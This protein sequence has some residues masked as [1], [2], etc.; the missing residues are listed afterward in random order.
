MNKVAGI[1]TLKDLSDSE[2]RDLILKYP[3][4]QNLYHAL[5]EQNI[6]FEGTDSFQDILHRTSLY[7][8]D[9]EFLFKKIR[10]LKAELQMEKL[11]LMELANENEALEKIELKDLEEPTEN[12]IKE[13]AA[14]LNRLEAKS[15]WENKG[16]KQIFDDDIDTDLEEDDYFDLSSDRLMPEED[17]SS[18]L[19]MLEKIIDRGADK[20]DPF[21]LDKQRVEFLTAFSKTLDSNMIVLSPSLTKKNVTKSTEKDGEVE[22]EI[23]NLPK[24]KTDSVIKPRKIKRPIKKQKEEA[25]ANPVGEEVVEYVEKSVMESQEVASETLAGLLVAQEQYGKAIKMYERLQLLFPEKSPYFAEQ[26][27]NLKKNL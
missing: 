27:D 16:K 11:D 12:I 15:E 7:S 20:E 17:R 13:E 18:G 26:I 3:Y 14:V 9:R 4:F 23:T 1:S 19:S 10:R 2:I 25:E 21:E 8:V 6:E 24:P 22:L 5:L